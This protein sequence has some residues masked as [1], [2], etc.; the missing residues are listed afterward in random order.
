VKVLLPM[1]VDAAKY[2]L[3]EQLS[4]CHDAQ[5]GM[6]REE[7]RTL[8]A[9]LLAHAAQAGDDRERRAL[10]DRVVVLNMEVARSIA[11]RYHG[12]GIADEDLDQVSFVGLVKAVRR[13]EVGYDGDLL[14]YAVPTIR[15]E[16]R[17]HFRDR[18]WTV[19]PP[20]RIQELQGRIWEASDHLVQELGR[21]PRPTEV[22]E[23][24]GE[25]IDDVVEALAAKECFTP[26]S[27]DRPVAP[28]ASTSLADL[29][30]SE[31]SQAGPAEARLV[32][33]P[34]VRR[35]K[36]RDRRILFL[37][38]FEGCTQE[39][40]AQEIGVTQM[41]VSRILS[42]IFSELRGQLENPADGTAARNGRRCVTRARRVAPGRR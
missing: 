6:S 5:I 22:A 23:F 2:T 30:G 26:A 11:S 21:S 32:L 28:G 20:R 18:G 27:L 16:I 17:R 8:T 29:Q 14:S 25:A 3:P 36:E 10:W 40:I 34:A 15:G 19:R 7:R 31:D 42:R 9:D 1:N 37:R 38:F 24:V 41:Q 4:G 39:E 12:R 13:F 35:L 33:A